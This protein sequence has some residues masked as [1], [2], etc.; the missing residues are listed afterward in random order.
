MPKDIIEYNA[1]E[2]SDFFYKYLGYE[3]ENLIGKNLKSTMIFKHNDVILR[4]EII[5]PEDNEIDQIDTKEKPRAIILGD[6]ND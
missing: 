4:F 2:I 1:K 6:D 5:P 3:R